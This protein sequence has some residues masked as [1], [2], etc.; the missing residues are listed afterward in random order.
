MSEITQPSPI[1]VAHYYA[2]LSAAIIRET[3]DGPLTHLGLNKVHPQS[4]P[5]EALRTL[6]GSLQGIGEAPVTTLRTTTAAPYLATI[7]ILRM[8]AHNEI[9]ASFDYANK[10]DTTQ[11]AF[12]VTYNTPNEATLQTTIHSY[13]TGQLQLR[14]DTLLTPEQNHAILSTFHTLSGVTLTPIL[15]KLA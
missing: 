2:A 12:A 1:D 9:Y 10:T 8:Q 13:T 14:R 4:T 6:K 11:L 3:A 5:A 7:G 15:K